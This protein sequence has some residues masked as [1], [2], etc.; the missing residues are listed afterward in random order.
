[1]YYITLRS[2]FAAENVGHPRYYTLQ[3]VEKLK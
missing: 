3:I 1:M 2:I